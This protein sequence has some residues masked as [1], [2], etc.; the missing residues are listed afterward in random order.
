MPKP[1]TVSTPAFL[2]L[3]EHLQQ[4]TEALAAVHSQDEVL[5]VVLKP[6]M[7][8]LKAVAGAVL[9]VDSTGQQ[10]WIAATEGHKA[11]AQT[12]W[13]DGP[14]DGNVPAGAALE[15]HQPLFFEHRAALVKAYPELEERTGAVAPVATAVLP[16]FLEG[17]PLGTIILDFEEPH[18]FTAEEKR[19]LQTLAA[20]TAF[21]L[22]RAQIIAE[23]GIEAERFRR[24]LE[25][26]PVG[27]AV[28]SLDGQLTLVNDAYLHLLGYTRAEYEANEM[29]WLVLTPEEYR[30]QDQRAFEAAFA[31]GISTTY[32]KEM[33]NK[34]GERLP[35]ELTLI[36][37][38]AD[39]VVGYL[40]DLRAQKAQQQLLR[41]EGERLGRLVC[42]RT[43]ALE[44]EQSASRVFI[45]FTEAA[46][47]L[48]QVDD[49]GRLALKTLQALMPDSSAVVYELASTHWHPRVWTENLNPKLLAV[50]QQGLPLTTPIFA[51]M[52]ER[53]AP[54]FV[55]GWTES[56]QGVAH[57]EQFQTVAAYPIVQQDQVCAVLSVA[58]QTSRAWTESQQTLIRA[59]GRSFSLLYDRISAARQ[60]RTQKE[61]AEH[62]V[63][64][65]EA[66][67][68]LTQ[69]VGTA[70]DPLTLIRQAQELTLGLLPPGF[71]AY[72]E[73]QDGRWRLLAQTGEA[74]SASLQAAI[75]RGFPIGHTPSFDLVAQTGEPAFV[76]T[77]IQ[78]TDVSAGE[79]KHIAAHATLP[80]LVGRQ[81]RGIFNLPMFQHHRWTAADRALLMT[82][83]QYLGLMLERAQSFEALTASNQELQASNEELEAFTYSASH[84]LRTPVRHV[85]GFAELAQKALEKTPNEKAQKYLDVVKQ[86]AQRMNALIDGML[87]LSRSGRQEINLQPVVLNDLVS[88]ARRDVAR[89]FAGHPVRWQISDL[90]LVKGDRGLLQQVLTNLLSNAVKYSSKRALS[91]VRV[92]SEENASE[93]CIHV[94]DNGVG[95]DPTYA[96]KLFG[97]FQRLHT[98][99][100]FNG[101]GVGLATVKRIVLKHGGRVSAESIDHQGATFSFTLPKK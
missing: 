47:Q 3:S 75:D 19:F 66:L 85:M 41:D 31:D 68:E 96:Q 28:G 37:H 1:S 93:W 95:F 77:Y 2:A 10:L 24:M 12:I 34:A 80:L 82:T 46:S 43:A 36:R 97:I 17:Q 14:L 49:L 59:V 44:A 92:W 73:A 5:P 42:D 84:D 88:Q 30:A 13:Q 35:L 60:V 20:Q 29:D 55:D 62:R 76:D 67:M 39:Q 23:R 69:G 74:G 83:V 32:E 78:D 65:L 98:E 9:L 100:E 99:R 63:Q 8:A 7:A 54:V 90:P 21:A 61:E 72:Y 11:G 33:L 50:L 4:V 89:E 57:T 27:M 91:E 26:S 64:A 71:A 45:Q 70:T 94:Q 16:M 79:A 53:Q 52:V 87:V 86:G 15:Q 48:N 40:K 81:L 58:L 6:A 25:A 51:Q 101:T 38:D 22:D 18:T 56:D